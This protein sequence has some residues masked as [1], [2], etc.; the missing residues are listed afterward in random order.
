M[1]NFYVYQNE[2]Q[3]GPFTEDQLREMLAAGQVAPE[4]HVWKEGTPDWVPLS[5]LELSKPK[6][7]MQPIHPSAG[8]P[9]VQAELAATEVTPPAARPVRTGP[10]PASAPL[11]FFDRFRNSWKLMGAS[12]QVLKANKSM[13]LLPLIS[14]ASAIL[15]IAT[16]LTPVVLYCVGHPELL[17]HGSEHGNTPIAFHPLYLAYLF[18]FY[19]CNY[20]VIIFFNCALVAGA[21][22]HM[23]GSPISLGES[24]K[25]AASRLPAILGWAAISATVGLILHLIE[26]AARDKKM[27]FVAKMI[28]GFLGAA[29]TIVTFLVLPALIVER[30]GP[31]AALKSSISM[32]KKTWGEQLI[33]NAGF[34]IAFSILCL[35][36]FGLMIAAIVLGIMTQSLVIGALLM[37]GGIL[38]LVLI[39]LAQSA[40]TVI[41]QTA[42]YFYAR[43]GVAPDGF[44]EATLAGAFAT[45]G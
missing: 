33:G 18:I 4:N 41:Y 37:C 3:T 34:G 35:P 13:L 11:G 44:G 25:A 40:M 2:Q 39:A 9:P 22:A 38:Y 20:T 32:I 19:F 5:T 16:F 8:A 31:V 42:L 43:D 7:R 28:T 29:W 27:E 12:F 45:K 17:K 30:I 23:Q 10:L 21:S 6:L 24:L 36:G 15:V 14:S 26:S 1:S